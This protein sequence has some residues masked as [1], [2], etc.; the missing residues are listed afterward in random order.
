MNKAVVVAAL[1][2]CGATVR[3]FGGGSGT[4]DLV[5]GN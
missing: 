4:P 3:D 2:A 1:R 5:V